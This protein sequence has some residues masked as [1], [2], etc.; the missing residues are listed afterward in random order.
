MHVDNISTHL[1]STGTA[2]ENPPI[3]L[4]SVF[5]KVDGSTA[6]VN[7]TSLP[8]F[9]LQG[10]A[11]VV[12]TPGDQGDLPGGV[13]ASYYLD[14]ETGIPSSLGDYATTL[15]PFPV[16]GLSGVTVGGMNT[17]ADAVAAGHQ[18]L[19]GAVQQALNKMIPTISSSNPMI[20]PSDVANAES[21]IRTQVVDAIINALSVWDKL[22]TVLNTEFQDAY[23]GMGL[24][25]FTDS[26][27]MVSPPQGLPLNYQFN[28]GGTDDPNLYTFTF[29]GTV[30]ANAPPYSLKRVLTGL[31][32]APPVSLLAAMGASARPSL[33]AWIEAVT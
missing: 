17:P 4:W 24:Q 7:A 8:S 6:Q 23:V 1:T 16:L 20:T 22:A 15:V 21:L 9:A 25:Y 14:E 26:Q 29:N 3:Y 32:H 10:T 31:G 2:F 33:L 18:A 30:L 19:N 28:W 13:R 27:L 5:F 11:T 12:P